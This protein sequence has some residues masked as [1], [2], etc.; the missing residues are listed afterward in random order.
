MRKATHDDMRFW[1]DRGVDGFR[2]DSM[3]LMSK[4]PGLPDGE[5]VTDEPY[6]DGS[7]FFASGPKMHEYIQTMR[8]EVSNLLAVD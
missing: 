6:Q 3:N 7:E 4:H 1:L 8:R 5:V 2:I